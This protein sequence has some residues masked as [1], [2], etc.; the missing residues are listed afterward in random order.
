MAPSWP[1]PSEEVDADEVG[2]VAGAGLGGDVGQGAGLHH[3]TSFEDDDA[4][5]EGEGV[6][7]IVG[8]EQADAVERGEVTA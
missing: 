4:V 3:L 2:D 8:D 7:G 6:D 1:T 5:G